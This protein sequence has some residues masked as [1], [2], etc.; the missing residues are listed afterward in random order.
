M[1]LIKMKIII[2]FLAVI[3]LAL[4]ASNEMCRQTEI[5]VYSSIQPVSQSFNLDVKKIKGIEFQVSESEFK[6][7]N[8]V[9]LEQ[10]GFV[11]EKVLHQKFLMLPIINIS[12]TNLIQ[13][14]CLIPIPEIGPKRIR[15]YQSNEKNLSQQGYQTFSFL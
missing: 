2:L 1:G 6:G 11:L 12:E 9:P 14:G 13:Y 8:L 15:H 5:K 10:V 4:V 7:S 3:S